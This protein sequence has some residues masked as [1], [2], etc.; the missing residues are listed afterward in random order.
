M[1]F[2]EFKEKFFNLSIFTTDQ[3]YSWYP[4]FDRNNFSRWVKK[5]LILR[6]RKGYYTFPEYK[7]IPHYSFYFANKIYK[8]SFISLHSAL[9][10][11]G[12]IPESIF[13]IT[14]VTTLKTE[15]FKNEIG[16]FVYKSI[17]SK[18]MFGY[19]FK[20]IDNA[21]NFKI[22]TPEKAI[23]DLL[24]LYPEYSTEEEILNLRFDEDLLPEL[25]NKDRLLQL[26]EKIKMNSLTNRIKLLIKV[27]GI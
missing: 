1:N 17:N 13:Q 22:S 14:S 5:G 15:N 18:V 12:L 27:Y 10:Y 21:K 3:V 9:S 25:I 2:L 24:Y 7:S 20:E 6:L 19:E 23:V 16:E 4:G 8:P 26:S 11:Y